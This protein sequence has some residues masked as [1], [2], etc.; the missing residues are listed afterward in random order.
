MANIDD[1]IL[2]HLLYIR[3]AV[4]ALRE[5]MHELKRPLGALEGG[6]LRMSSQLD[7]IDCRIARIEQRLAPIDA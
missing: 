1:Q 6:Y 5:D 2:E 7:R 4:D 3:G